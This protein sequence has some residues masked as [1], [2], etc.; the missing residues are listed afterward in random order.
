MY[1][2]DIIFESNIFAFLSFLNH[3][4]M[5]NDN[6]TT[7]THDMKKDQMIKK[8]TFVEVTTATCSIENQSINNK[9]TT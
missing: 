3:L 7:C 4:M 1:H 5:A 2:I 8:S 9:G 6:S